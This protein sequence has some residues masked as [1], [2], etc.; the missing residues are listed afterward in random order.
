[1]AE[2]N[3]RGLVVLLANFKGGVGKS[4]I[5]DMLANRLPNS[6]LLN[7]DIAQ[8]AE[9]I[10]SSPTINIATVLTSEYTPEEI[11]NQKLSIE[12]LN[13]LKEAHDYVILDTPGE[14]T[15]E[16]IDILSEAKECIDYIVIPTMPGKR[17]RITTFTTV[18]AL[19]KS[20]LL[21]VNH[22]LFYV[23]N[24][25]N[26]DSIVDNEINEIKNFM[27]NDLKIPVK[28]T[29]SKLKNSDAVITMEDSQKSISELRGECYIAYAAFE[30]RVN[31]FISDFIT[32]LGENK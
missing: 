24:Q 22:K 8:D 23:I 18:N 32:F 31:A 21:T 30:K 5:A 13:M 2:L 3:K 15:K 16:L 7:I 25:Y 6:I 27:D 26:S 19:F 1:M 29:F 28:Y 20:E 10:N 9:S 17:T 14:Q 11:E 12:I 4:T